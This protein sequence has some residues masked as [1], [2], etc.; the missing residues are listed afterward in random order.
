M[1]MV[2]EEFLDRLDYYQSS[3][4]PARVVVEEAVKERRQ[5][6]VFFLFVLFFC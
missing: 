4:L 6:Q 1:K 5:V 3:W 2:G